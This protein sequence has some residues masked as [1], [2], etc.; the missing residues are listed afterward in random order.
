MAP[1]IE[2]P[3]TVGLSKSERQ[4]HRAN[5]AEIGFGGEAEFLQPPEVG[6][7]RASVIG[8]IEGD[9]AEPCRD[10]RVVH[11]VAELPAV[12]TGGVQQEKRRALSGFFDEDAVTLA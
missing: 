6:R 9:D 12:V 4:P 5:D 7:C 11:Q 8:H 3:S 1:P 2:Q 10:R